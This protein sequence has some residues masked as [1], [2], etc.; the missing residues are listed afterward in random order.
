M[1]VLQLPTYERVGQLPIKQMSDI[2]CFHS[3][4]IAHFPDD[5]AELR[6]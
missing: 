4:N 6:S 5:G 2:I 3:V 1:E